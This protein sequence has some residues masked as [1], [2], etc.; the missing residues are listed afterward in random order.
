[1]IQIK[2]IEESLEFILRHKCSVAR[3]GDGEMD[4]IAGHSIPYQEYDAGLAERLK[5]IIGLTSNE[6][7]LVCLSDVFERRERY[8]ANFQLFWNGH[9]ERY[10]NLY[11]ELCQ[12]PWY[13][14][15]FISRPYIDL[16][17]KSLSG[18][19]FEK[20]KALWQD[21]DVLIVEGETSRSGVGNDL[22]AG[23]QSVS[24]I[25]CP[26]K[27]AY[28]DYDEIAGA[29]R[30]YGKN[31]LILLMLGPTAKVLSYELSQ[32]G[33]WTIDM[34][35]IDSEY[36][37]FQMGATYKVKLGHKHTAEH[38]YD[39]GIVLVEDEQYVHQVV[40]RIGQKRIAFAL[41]TDN[42][43]ASHLATLLY[44]IHR[45]HQEQEVIVYI[46]QRDVTDQ[47]KTYLSTLVSSF[48]D[49]SIE[50]VQL[51]EEAMSDLRLRGNSW[52][53]ETYARLFLPRLL[54][55]EE[56]V[57]YLDVDTLVVDTLLP[58]WEMDLGAAFLGAVPEELIKEQKADYLA[59]IGLSPTSPYVNAG[60]LLMDL[61]GLR[62]AGMAEKMVLFAKEKSGELLFLDQ[63]VI[64]VVLEGRILLLEKRYNYHN[65]FLLTRDYSKE[66]QT[67][68]HYGG[69]RLTK[70]WTNR[71]LLFD[72]IKPAAHLY[73]Q[74]REEALECMR[75][76]YPSVTVVIPLEESQAVKRHLR[77][78]VDSVLLQ[79]HPFVEIALLVPE[80]MSKETLRVLDEVQELPRVRLVKRKERS[81]LFGD[82]LKQMDS[83]YFFFLHPVDVLEKDCLLATTSQME[84]HAAGVAM[85]DYY[86][87]REMDGTMLFHPEVSSSSFLCSEQPGG[88]AD[89]WWQDLAGKCYGQAEL[90]RLEQVTEQYPVLLLTK[91]LYMRREL[92]RS[93]RSIRNMLQQWHQDLISIVIPVY[94]VESYL[95]EC[96]ESALKQ[97]YPHLEIILVNDGSTDQSGDLCNRYAADYPSIRVIHQENKGASVAKNTGIAHA[98]GVFVTLLDSDDVLVDPMMVQTLYDQA[99][100]HQADIAIGNYYEY[101]QSDGHF[102]YRNLDEDFCIERVTA[103]QAIDRQANWGHLNTSAFVIT[104]G[105][106]IR[107]SLFEGIEFPDGRMFDDEF[108]TH[109]L[110]LQAKGI[111]LVNG[112]YYLYRR[113]HGSMMSSGYSLKRVQDIIAVFQE[114]LTDLVLAGYDTH[115][116]RLRYRNVL[117]DYKQVMEAYQLTNSQEYRLICYKLQ[118]IKDGAK[119][120]GKE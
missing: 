54:A 87:F 34:G 52:T 24:R 49:F 90:E 79:S 107:R 76:M 26:S 88:L 74:Y 115:E 86:S 80:K 46:C 96:I 114:K 38:N 97:T 112:N 40:R 17:D 29:I 100:L 10:E 61:A 59:S 43:Y 95:E 99:I 102:Y 22:F 111:V 84:E 35:H 27:N 72:Y 64:N 60:V 16:E 48:P 77:E 14:S 93:R 73:R 78:C 56:R 104:A 58:L 92:S 25:I 108:V 30:K 7:F 39:E 33:Y 105:K 3:F 41:A 15:T 2:P 12:A 9:L 32:E 53:L 75:Q 55:N 67:V 83:D 1:M 89:E 103:Q 31:R 109:K 11:E 118:L 45:H 50:W 85:V 5:Q 101:D 68:I 51:S 42:G 8:N 116:T 91:A 117:N 13:G 70:P 20:L 21:R 81:S 120:G 69:S 62:Q 106:L 82:V 44:S 23:A 19:Y 119:N 63:D 6:S 28:A 47:M 57:I 36:E 71:V 18:R 65:D 113:G 94:N 4:I 66:N 110:Y 37:W 98:G